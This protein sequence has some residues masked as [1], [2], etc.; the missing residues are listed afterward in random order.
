MWSFKLCLSFLLL[1]FCRLATA[2]ANCPLYGSLLPRPSNLLQHAGIQT[3]SNVLSDIF[4]RYIDNEKAVGSE[5]FSYAVEVFSA[6]EDKPLWSHYWTAPS[7]KNFNSS[8]VITVDANPVFRIGSITK[9]FTV[10]TFLATVGDGIWNDPITEHLPEIHDIASE[11]SKGAIFTPDW[12][13]IT[14][15][16]LASQTSGLIR[17]CMLN[18]ARR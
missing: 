11:E 5:Y 18:V 16:S 6:T 3:A 4:P 17:D 9:V 13:S 1:P 15:G 14:V 8:G 2:K 10:L 12:E 7:L